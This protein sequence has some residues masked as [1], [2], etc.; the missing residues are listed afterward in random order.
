MN[1][2]WLVKRRGNV[3]ERKQGH[4]WIFVKE[5]S[6]PG[7]ADQWLMNRIRE[8]KLVSSDWTIQRLAQD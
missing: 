1:I 4:S 6:N 8:N 5:F 7:Q 2:L 3:Q